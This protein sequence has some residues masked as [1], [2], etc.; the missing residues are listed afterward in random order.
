MKQIL[1]GNY[2][3]LSKCKINKFLRKQHMLVCTYYSYY[4]WKNECGMDL[5]VFEDDISSSVVFVFAEAVRNT[6]FN[7]QTYF[8]R[9]W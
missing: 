5:T 6:T 3:D 7:N 2:F 8:D 4:L 1:L 9:G